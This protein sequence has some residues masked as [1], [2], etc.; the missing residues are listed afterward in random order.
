MQAKDRI[1]LALDVDTRE[2]AFK[3]VDQLKD[4]VGVYKIGMQLYNSYGPDIVR[5]FNGMGAKVFVDLKFHDIPNTVAAASRVMT[6]LN[7]FMFNM[8]VSGGCEMMQQ[9]M[10]AV[11]EEAAGLGREMPM[12]LAVTVLTS[13]TA[14]QLENELGILGMSV[15]DLVVKWAKIAQ[16]EGLTGIVCSPQ[17]I[18][19]IRKACGPDFKIVT[20]GIRPVWS[21]PNDQKRITTP[22][23]A[24]QMGADYLV[25]GRPISAAA[26]AVEAAQRIIA[27]MEEAQSC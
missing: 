3:L 1:V 27:E 25:I 16:K 15:E 11:R 10:A 17:E 7:A 5:E 23:E 8:H 12:V 20:P 13:I 21:A 2:E 6:R 26:D 4:Y 9:A 14:A 22:R 24:L 18:K 19:A